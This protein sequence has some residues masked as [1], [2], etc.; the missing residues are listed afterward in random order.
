MELLYL[1]WWTLHH[2]AATH[3]ILTLVLVKCGLLLRCR[4]EHWILRYIHRPKSLNKCLLLILHVWVMNVRVLFESVPASHHHAVAAG[5]V[6]GLGLICLIEEHI[7]PT[8]IVAILLSLIQLLLRRPI[9]IE[10]GH[11]SIAE[12]SHQA[13]IV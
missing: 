2:K 9:L 5:V 1:R 7:I 12:L 10:G 6:L 3:I 8:L 4:E 13:I 11:V